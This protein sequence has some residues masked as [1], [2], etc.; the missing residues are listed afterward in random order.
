MCAFLFLFAFIRFYFE[1]KSKE[2]K[3]K[4]Y[5]ITESNMIRQ[6]NNIQYFVQNCT[7]KDTNLSCG[8]SRNFFFSRMTRKEEIFDTERRKMKKKHLFCVNAKRPK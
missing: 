7:S 4:Y 6:N 1:N 8:N 5:I 3:M 2:K